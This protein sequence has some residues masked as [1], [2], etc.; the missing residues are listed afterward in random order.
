MNLE[1]VT[2][3]ENS[4]KAATETNAWGF[5][6]V[7]EYDDKGNLLQIYPNA[8]EAARAVGILPSSMRNS[9]RR[10]GK[11]SNGLR[12]KYIENK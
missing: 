12:Y 4:R 3:K 9:I 7:G 2:P 10:E 1:Q 5:K 8:S 11:C 6:Q